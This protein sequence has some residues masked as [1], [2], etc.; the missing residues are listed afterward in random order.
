[1]TNRVSAEVVVTRKVRDGWFVY[2]C[3]DLPGLYVAHQDDQIAYNDLPLAI[4]LLVKLDEGIDCAVSHAVPYA[5]FV[6]Q[7]R[8]SSRAAE[9]LQKRTDDLISNH[10][11]QIRFVLQPAGAHQAGQ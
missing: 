9:E 8:L 5:E 2:T 7:A 10:A 6:K 1:M 11:D 4:K 3:E